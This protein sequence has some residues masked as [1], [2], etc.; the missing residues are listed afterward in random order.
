MSRFRNRLALGLVVALLASVLGTTHAVAAPKH[1]KT[2]PGQEAKAER[3]AAPKVPNLSWHPCYKKIAADYAEFA[4]ELEVSFEC[5]SVPVPLDYDGGD[6]GTIKLAVVRLPALDPESRIGSLFTNPGGPGGSGV[7]FALFSAPFAF[8]PDVRSQFDIIGF[9]PRGILLSTPARCYANQQK[10]DATASGLSTPRTDAEIQSWLDADAELQAACAKKG[11]RILD[12]MSTANVARDMDLLRQAVGDEQLTYAGYS[13]G[14]MVGATYANLFPDNIRAMVLDSALDPVAWTTGRGDGDTVPVTSRLGSHIGS[15]DSLD[16]F[17][18]LCEEAGPE[19]CPIADDPEGRWQGV[20]D[21]LDAEPLQLPD[22]DPLTGEPTGETF[23]FRGGD[24]L[25]LTV[26]VLYAGDFWPD[27]AFI[28]A[29]LEGLI[30][31]APPMFF[32]RTGADLAALA[33][34]QP[35]SISARSGSDLSRTPR[36]FNFEAFPTVLCTDSDNPDS[37]DAY[38]A[39]ADATEAESVF[40]ALWTWNGSLCSD[41]PSADE[42]RYT[43][44]WDADTCNTVLILNNTFDPATPIEGA[45]AMDAELGNSKLIEVVGGRGHIAV[46]WSDCAAFVQDSYLLTTVI[47][48]IDSCEP[49]FE[50]PFDLLGG[51]PGVPA[52]IEPLDGMGEPIV[53]ILVEGPTPDLPVALDPET[54]QPINIT[55]EGEVLPI[56]IVEILA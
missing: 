51:P 35:N 33:A 6:G 32:E 24:F 55:D 5:A 15:Q 8:G 19:L 30:A 22:F 29:D 16:E 9:D 44:P 13:Y 21:A 25:G 46:Q 38:Y 50:S 43:G 2:P 3:T 18:R 49:T 45:R 28:V 36:Y 47:P 26:G 53:V 1:D 23:P 27:I 41:W 56:V 52:L 39:A 12:H 7:E 54:G 4:P 34:G 31:G 14:T 17:F 40:G 48:P 10:L 11:K 20:L 37:I 42:D